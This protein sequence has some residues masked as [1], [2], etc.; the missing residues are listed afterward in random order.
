MSK[1]IKE[2]QEDSDKIKGLRKKNEKQLEL[3]EAVKSIVKEL[4][5]KSVP[6]LKAEI[7]VENV[8]KKEGL[9]VS[10]NRVKKIIKEE[11]GL[12]YRLTKKVPVQGS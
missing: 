1:L 2:A 8:K 10:I 5:E 12:S 7:V 4:L 9:E 6:I 11:M 3:E